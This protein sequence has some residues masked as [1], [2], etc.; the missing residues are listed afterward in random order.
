MPE[1]EA[2][3]YDTEFRRGGIVV[4]AQARGRYDEARAILREYGG[5]DTETST[6][7][8]AAWDTT[9]P[10]FRTSYEQRYGTTR[11]WNDVE[12]AHRFGYE[13]YG[14]TRTADTRED[15]G[16]AEPTLREE[17]T[18]TNRTGD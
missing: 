13:S 14:R 15:F 12:P 7:T 16:T 4:T 5:R 1:D 3:Y 2:H 6:A 8:Y 10:R 9:A 11:P 18:R 17:W